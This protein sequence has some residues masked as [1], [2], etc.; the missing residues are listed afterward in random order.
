MYDNETRSKLQNIISGTF[1]EGQSDYCT[2][3]RNYL[4]KSFSTSTNVKTNFDHHYKIKEE[5]AVSLVAFA[6]E[7][8]SLFIELPQKIKYLAQ[9]GE[10]KIYLEN[11]CKNVI[12]VNDAVYYTTWLD[13]LNSMLIHNLLFSKTA[14]TLLGFIKE[15]NCLKAIMRQPYIIADGKVDLEVVKNILN[16]NGFNNIK[17]C[18]YYNSELSLILEDIHDENVIIQNNSLFFI[19]TVFY[20]NVLN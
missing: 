6:K 9:G 8:K 2:A 13:F 7:N 3:A 18:D 19:D 12:K 15:E 1:L 10:A 14:Y 4:C 17:N 20:I 5:Q 16:F 11:D